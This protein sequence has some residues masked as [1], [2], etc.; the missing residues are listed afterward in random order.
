MMVPTANTLRPAM[1]L[2]LLLVMGSTWGLQFSM[3]KFAAAGGYS[4]L[5]VL[6]IAMVLLSVIY[7]VIA[8]AKG[9]RLAY[10]RQLP[11]FLIITSILGYIAPLLALLH[12]AP[13]LPAGLMTLIASLSPVIAVSLALVL[14]TE[15]VSRSRALA[16]AIGLLSTLIILWPELQLPGYG[17]AGWILL[18]M[19]VPL[20]Y[21][22]ES[23]FI[24]RF[25]PAG[26]TTLHAVS[27]ETIIA[28]ILV[29]P[30]YWIY[31][32]ALPDQV[33]WTQAETAI[34]VF[35]LASVAEGL[36]YFYLIKRTGG[37]LVNFGGFVALFAGIFWGWVFFSETHPANV[38]L[39]VAVLVTAL[40][41]A[42]RQS[43]P[44]SSGSRS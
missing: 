18:A 7:L 29:F 3:L 32:D 28:A 27:G 16:V 13:H 9:E 8:L 20:V 5:T 30:V 38:W 33:R 21:G 44:A 19:T 25:W 35:V 36:I 31:G 34:A 40:A 41:L 24:S 37:V 39:A 6:M 4:E 10:S 23:I 15:R 12:A 42:N 26:L 1:A 17:K 22:A 2:A 11:A 43:K 14:R